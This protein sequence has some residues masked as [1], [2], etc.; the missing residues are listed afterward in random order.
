[1]KQFLAHLLFT[2]FF[3]AL[4]LNNADQ[5]DTATVKPVYALPDRV[6]EFEPVE[7]KAMIFEATAYYYGNVTSTGTSPVAYRTAAVDPRIIP[8][9]TE[10]T[11]DAFPGVVW[12]AEDCGNFWSDEVSRSGYYRHIR[13]NRIDLR[14]PDKQTCL[15]FG[16]R[17]VEVRVIE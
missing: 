4:I 7:S 11:V 15:E 10:F 5:I 14:M 13:G 6:V 12:V 8:Y 2:I 1:M 17:Q 16:R 9:G 3:I